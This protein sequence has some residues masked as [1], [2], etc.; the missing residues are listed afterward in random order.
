MY[1][2]CVRA[3]VP[4]DFL[5]DLPVVVLDCF[6]VHQGAGATVL[7]PAPDPSVGCGLFV[8]ALILFGLALGL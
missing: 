5:V 7:G 2:A 3:C 4:T 1:R 8:G 6:I